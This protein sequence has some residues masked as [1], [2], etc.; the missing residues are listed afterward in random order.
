MSNF[1]STS[2][3]IQREM[4]VLVIL[5]SITRKAYIIRPYDVG[6]KRQLPNPRLPAYPSG[7]KTLQGQPG[8]ENQPN[9]KEGRRAPAS[10]TAFI[11]Y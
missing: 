5:H 10:K 1:D 3:I 6:K 7:C 9:T 2:R 8:K 4:D 11:E